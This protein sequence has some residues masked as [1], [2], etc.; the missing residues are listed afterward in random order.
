MSSLPV[1][2]HAAT[3]GLGPPDQVAFVVE[4]L[5]AALPVYTALFGPFEVRPVKRDERLARGRVVSPTLRVAIGRCG[6]LEIELIQPVD[7][8][9]PHREHLARHG[10]GLHHVRFR[11]DDFDAKRDALLAAGYI[12]TF[13]GT[14][15]RSRYVYLEAPERLGHTAIELIR[16]HDQPGA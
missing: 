1:E 6:D 16:P 5:D 12:S 2:G 9:S 11:V 7:G 3:F 14:S 4:D 8:E 13:E 15:T 10:E